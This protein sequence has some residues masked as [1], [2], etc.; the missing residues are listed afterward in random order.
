MSW[1]IWCR[2]VI[3]YQLKRI[4]YKIWKLYV[5]LVRIRLFFTLVWIFVCIIVI[6]HFPE[7]I[8]YR[9]HAIVCKFV[10]K[11]KYILL[12]FTLCENISINYKSKLHSAQVEV[13][14]FDWTWLIINHSNIIFI[15]GHENYDILSTNIFIK[16]S[17]W[18]HILWPKNNREIQFWFSL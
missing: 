13:H 3:W 1:Y 10:H 8:Q 16:S 7:M 17:C 5:E 15:E 18:N 12:V 2:N 6:S 9:D 14:Y 4:G 11:H